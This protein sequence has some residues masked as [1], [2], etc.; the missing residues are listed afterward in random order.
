[1]TNK[2]QSIGIQYFTELNDDGLVNYPNENVLQV[3]VGDTIIFHIKPGSKISNHPTLHINLPQ[4]TSENLYLKAVEFK[5]SLR[6]RPSAPKL[7]D[8]QQ[9]ED[10]PAAINIEPKISTFGLNEFEVKFDY[11]GS[12]F[13]QIEYFDEKINTMSIFQSCKLQRFY[14]T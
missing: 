10:E 2:L 6:K 3:N 14:K 1:M 5:E 12:F 8:S 13:Y 7:A 9:D 11:P 4:I